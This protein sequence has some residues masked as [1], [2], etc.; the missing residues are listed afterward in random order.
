M[1]RDDLLKCLREQPMDNEEQHS[2]AERLLCAY[3]RSIDDEELAYA[4]ECAQE[5]QVWW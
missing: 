2:R 1:T 3:L 4:W 5:Y